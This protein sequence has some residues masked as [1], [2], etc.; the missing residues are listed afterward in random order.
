M[1]TVQEDVAVTSTGEVLVVEHHRTFDD[2]H[3]MTDPLVITPSSAR[4][5]ADHIVRAFAN[6][7]SPYE[8]VSSIRRWT[9]QRMGRSASSSASSSATHS[10]HVRAARSARRLFNDM[11]AGWYRCAGAR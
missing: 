3:V 2:G 7:S 6:Q 9:V 1:S 8:L 11:A 4:W 10:A 5:L